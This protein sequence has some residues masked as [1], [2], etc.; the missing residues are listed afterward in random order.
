MHS[1][2]MFCVSGMFPMQVMLFFNEKVYR[3]NRSVKSDTDSFTAFTSPNMGPLVKLEINIRGTCERLLSMSTFICHE[4][5][6][7]F[8]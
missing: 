4:Q 1:C 5:Q 3:G 8:I 2:D 7:V 6:V